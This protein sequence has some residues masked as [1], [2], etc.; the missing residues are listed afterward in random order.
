VSSDPAL[1]REVTLGESKCEGMRISEGW[2][3]EVIPV[4]H[5]KGHVEKIFHFG[6]MLLRKKRECVEQEIPKA[7]E[8]E[9]I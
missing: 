8:P 9:F 5:W 4:V 3:L 6:G 7:I 1:R 2:S